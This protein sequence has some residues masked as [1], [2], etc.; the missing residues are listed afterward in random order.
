MEPLTIY[1][2]AAGGSYLV[3]DVIEGL[4]SMKGQKEK[5]KRWISEADTL[6]NEGETYRQ[7]G[8]RCKTQRFDPLEY[9]PIGLVGRAIQKWTYH[10]LDE[11]MKQK[12]HEL[13]LKE[14]KDALARFEPTGTNPMSKQYKIQ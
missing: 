10:T 2:A 11:A 1:A 14:W 8:E 12:D 9:K 3:V 4:A 5:V 13:K 7:Y 6:R